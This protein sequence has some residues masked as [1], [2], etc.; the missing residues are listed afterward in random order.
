VTSLA[1]RHAFV[2]GAGS[3]IGAAIA[4]AL[5][6]AGARV[7][8]TGRREAALR[9]VADGLERAA[10]APADLTDR[11]EIER[12]FAS[13]REAH[14]AVDILVNNAG[15]APSAPFAKIAPNEWREVMATN[16]DA[17]FHCC[18]SALP[19]LL[20][21]KDGRIITIA[22]T[23]G[24]KGYAYT[25]AYV[26]SKHAVVGLMRALAAEFARTELTANAICPGFTD[27]PIVARSA[28]RIAEKDDRGEEEALA[29]LKRFNPQNR[30]VLP[31]EV[32][33]AVVWL[34]DP[35]SRSLTGLALPVAGGEI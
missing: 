28:K 9:E 31:E 35:A 17:V 5:H 14:G 33:R 13:A 2:T 7:T 19:D 4:R 25:G 29:A 21:T 3:G 11:G 15:I 16:C 18:Q 23:A 26:A 8:L 22:S 34:A 30:L 20:A 1:G 32:A 6:A 27:T 10:I 24:L 12:A